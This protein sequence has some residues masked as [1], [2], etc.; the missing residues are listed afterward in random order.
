M[1]ISIE[2]RYDCIHASF[3]PLRGAGGHPVQGKEGM[4]YDA[5]RANRTNQPCR[6]ITLEPMLVAVRF[7]PPSQGQSLSND[8]REEWQSTTEPNG[9]LI[10]LASLISG[11]AGAFG[12]GWASNTYWT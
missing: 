5:N 8:H 6:E 10:M 7:V 1:L 4:T 3:V 11:I 9:A 12:A 2:R